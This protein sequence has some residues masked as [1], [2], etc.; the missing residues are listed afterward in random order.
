MFHAKQ[1][2]AQWP[3]H[4]EFGNSSDIETIR[5]GTVLLQLL[6]PP[7]ILSVLECSVIVR[8]V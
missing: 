5:L 4:F 1:T 7:R 2:S 8:R 6:N 3:A